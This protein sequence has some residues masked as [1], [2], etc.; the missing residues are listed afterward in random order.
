MTAIVLYK[1]ALYAD[2]QRMSVSLTVCH[3]SSEG[4]KVFIS[5]DQEFAWARAGELPEYDTFP[6]IE[7][8]LRQLIGHFV[9]GDE[10]VSFDDVDPSV[11]G[12]GPS[13]TWFVLTRHAGIV[14]TPI[15]SV[16]KT[17]MFES[18]GD[19]LGTG[20]E[21]VMTYLLLGKSPKKAFQL[22]NRLDPHTGVTFDRVK[23]RHL[24]EFIIK[25][26]V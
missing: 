15:Q 14:I 2:R 18:T 5:K 10:Q 1:N 4:P 6:K 7:R 19:A 23:R 9:V 16:D 22:T 25:K 12:T 26:E 8:T 11:L 3:I 13:N 17:M 21:L 20:G 24:K